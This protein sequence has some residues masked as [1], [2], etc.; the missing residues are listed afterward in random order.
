VFLVSAAG[1]TLNDYFDY[2]KDK[3]NNP[4]RPLPSNNVSRESALR[5]SITFFVFGNLISFS[6][7]PK[8]VVI[9]MLISALLLSYSKL[10]ASKPAGGV[11]ANVL[12]ACMVCCTIAF[13][14]LITGEIGNS[15]WAATLTFLLIL[16]REILKDIID[17]KGD[18]IFGVATLPVSLGIRYASIVVA[19]LFIIV[20][21]LNC[22]PIFLDIVNSIYIVMIL[23]FNVAL[24]CF[25]L[26]VLLKNGEKKY[27]ELIQ[28]ATLVLFFIGI[29]ALHFGLL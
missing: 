8:A 1:F 16:S 11:I 10:K 3:V 20:A 19:S 22:V 18:A 27:L 5:L 15:P 6:I 21:V 7:A 14:A 28:N 4:C 25:A 2:S 26:I 24:I 9:T 23:L 12:T 17:I 13:A 29:G